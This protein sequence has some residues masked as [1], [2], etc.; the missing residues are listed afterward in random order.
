MIPDR[1]YWYADDL[2]MK[3]EPLIK[4]LWEYRLK[5]DRALCEMPWANLISSKATDGKQYPILDLDFD[6]LVVDSSTDGHH[7]LFLNVGMSQFRW[8]VLM[9][10]LWFC[11]VIE[12]GN[13]VWS[14]RRGQTFVRVPGRQKTEEEYVK[15]TYGWFKKL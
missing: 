13:A 12:M 7:H 8:V 4:S 5:D 14:L 10:A 1:T 15:P 2:G 11:G 9:L 6:H 3:D